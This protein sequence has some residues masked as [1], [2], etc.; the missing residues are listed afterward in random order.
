MS[1]VMY[2]CVCLY[3]CHCMVKN[4]YHLVAIPKLF[5]SYMYCFPN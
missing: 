3:V 1:V 2:V 5:V 4:L